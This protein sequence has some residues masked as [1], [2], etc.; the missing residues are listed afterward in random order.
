MNIAL[1]VVLVAVGHG[2]AGRGWH[3]LSQA[4]AVLVFVADAREP[5]TGWIEA[6]AL[7]RMPA[8]D[9]LRVPAGLQSNMCAI[10]VII[11]TAING[12]HGQWRP[13]RRGK[14]DG[15]SG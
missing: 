2:R 7:P 11:Q 4:S 15:S 12:L 5:C 10:S 14:V 6:G 9:I 13:G 1:D 8:G 3:H